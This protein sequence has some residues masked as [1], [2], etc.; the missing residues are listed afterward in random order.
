MCGTN[1]ESQLMLVNGADVG[2]AAG[3]IGDVSLFVNAGKKADAEVGLRDRR[4][5]R[6]AAWPDGRGDARRLQPPHQQP[7][8]PASSL[9]RGPE[10][11]VLPRRVRRREQQVGGL[12]WQR[13]HG[14]AVG[15]R[16]GRVARRGARCHKRGARADRHHVVR[17]QLRG[18]H[19][20]RVHGVLGH[21]VHRGRKGPDPATVASRTG[22]T[23]IGRA[24]QGWR[25]TKG[26]GH[27]GVHGPS[28]SAS[29]RTPTGWSC[30]EPM[31]GRS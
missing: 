18:G 2:S 1:A 8:L 12:Q 4:G 9:P 6:V 31:P 16:A 30:A 11:V 13:Q 14:D 3:G 27:M 25:S 22:C 19:P 10:R 24:A 7:S 5:G 17:D 21:A 29:A 23:A 26:G 28:K 20:E 15:V